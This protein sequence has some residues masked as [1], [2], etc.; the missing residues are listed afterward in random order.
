[1]YLLCSCNYRNEVGDRLSPTYECTVCGLR[2]L[3]V[4]SQNLVSYVYNPG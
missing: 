4:G 2:N 1:M 3:S